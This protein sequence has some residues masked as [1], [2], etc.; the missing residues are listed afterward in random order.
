MGPLRKVLAAGR[1][2]RGDGAQSRSD[3]AADRPAAPCA[4]LVARDGAKWAEG[5]CNGDEPL[6]RCAV[7][8]RELVDRSGRAN[9]Q[10]VMRR[11]A[12]ACPQG[13]TTG[14]L[15]AA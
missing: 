9:V 3:A 12:C 1:E 14:E 4:H 10:A 7:V 11:A 8:P 15:D 5:D 2:G 6:P 13:L